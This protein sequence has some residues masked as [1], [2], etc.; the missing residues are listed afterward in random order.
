MAMILSSSAFL[1]L[2]SFVLLILC[3]L[4]EEVALKIFALKK[5]FAWDG[6]FAV[7]SGV[8]GTF[9]GMRH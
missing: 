4:V 3:K 2:R 9:E 7:R 1:L 6:L 5:P 8:D